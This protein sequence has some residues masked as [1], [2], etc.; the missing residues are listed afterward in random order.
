MEDAESRGWTVGSAVLVL[1][2]RRKAMVPPPT[3][4][5]SVP[6]PTIPI[7]RARVRHDSPVIG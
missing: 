7:P 5:P 4:P 2:E 1:P 3:I 6:L